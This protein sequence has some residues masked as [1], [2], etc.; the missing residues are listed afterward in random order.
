LKVGGVNGFGIVAAHEL[1]HRKTRTAQWLA[2]LELAV[3]AY[4]H[5]FVEHNRGHHRHVATPL[6]PASARM[7]ESFWRFLPRSVVGSLRSA[8]ALERGRLAQLGQGPWTLA[9]HTVT[10]LLLYQLQ[11]HADHHAQPARQYQAL[12]HFDSSP[13]LP[14]GYASMLLLAY[15]PPLWFAVMDPRVLRHYGGDIHLAHL[16]PPARRRLLQRHARPA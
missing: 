8:W 11:R 6:N 3:A 4:G 13:Q 14:S 9:N 12:R 7:G 2:K 10:N 15:V 1:G 5:F 16:H